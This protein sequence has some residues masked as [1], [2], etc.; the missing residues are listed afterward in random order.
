MKKK[1]WKFMHEWISF[2]QIKFLI[3]P[4]M[5]YPFNMQIKCSIFYFIVSLAF[6]QQ[7]KIF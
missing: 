2:I 4:Y 6:T 7:K 3:Q 5:G 1:S